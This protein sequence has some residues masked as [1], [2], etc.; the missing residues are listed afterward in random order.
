MALVLYGMS[1]NFSSNWNKHDVFRS[2]SKIARALPERLRHKYLLFSLKLYILLLRMGLNTR[3]GQPRSLVTSA[4]AIVLTVRRQDW[5]QSASFGFCTSRL[6]GK[7]STRSYCWGL[8]CC[9]L[10]QLH[11]DRW[12]QL[13]V[14]GTGAH[15]KW[16]HN[17]NK[18]LSIIIWFVSRYT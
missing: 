2:A 14:S 13:N 9:D 3:K 12:Q 8:L 18:N 5:N 11:A 17:T 16:L 4:R 10:W 1:R 7:I 6:Y 15:D